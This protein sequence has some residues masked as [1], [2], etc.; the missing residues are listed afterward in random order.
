MAANMKVHFN[1]LI[2]I[3]LIIFSI[4]LQISSCNDPI[5]YM[6][7]LETEILEP[8]INGSP[9]NFAVYDHKMYTA[10]GKKI[11]SY[12]DG[13]W[14]EWKRMNDTVMM[15]ASTDNSLYVLYL[16]NSRGRIIRYD[17]NGVSYEDFDSSHNIQ[18]IYTAGNVLFAS[19]REN[20]IYTTYYFDEV[21]SPDPGK[22]IKIENVDSGSLLNG[23]ASDG[24]FYYLCTA[25]GIYCV[26]PA[27]FSLALPD[28]LEPDV[29]F[30]GIIN[31]NK[32][33]AAAISVNGRIFEINNKICTETVKTG[34][35]DSQNST[36]ALALWYKD[37]DDS[38]PPS[39]LLAGRMEV[40]YTNTTGYS[41]GYVEFELDDFGRIKEN[42]ANEPGKN[43]LSSVD[44]Y[45]RY[46]SSIR[47]KPINYI[48][49]TPSDVDDEMTLF[50]S[51]QQ[52]G[53]WS[54]R[55]RKDGWQWNAEAEE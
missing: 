48:I 1:K 9:V 53:V 16:N 2:I 21:N 27:S 42:A 19:V 18:S 35:N 25:S 44:D 39:L 28:P 23:A 11:F 14:S 17:V 15:L 24:L 47:K 54:Y 12:S 6:V 49:Q 32:D 40:Y 50:A 34:F 52:N 31:L 4:V 3:S 10:S 26:D 41:N 46:T 30:T 37:N 55:D 7:H 20:N 8:I 43:T 38:A 5:F 22:L 51:T 29:R 33:Y 13:K 45:D 36:G